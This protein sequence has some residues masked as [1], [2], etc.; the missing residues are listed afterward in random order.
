M[1]GARMRM[2]FSPFFTL[3]PSSFHFQNPAT[4]VASGFTN[5]YRQRN[6]IRWKRTDG[7]IEAVD[8]MDQAGYGDKRIQPG[9]PQ[10][11][12]RHQRMN[13]TLKQYPTNP[14]AKTLNAQQKRFDE[15]PFNLF[16]SGKTV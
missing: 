13:R 15:L 9:K 16:Q 7:A 2:P 6:T 3:R 4:R 10:Q 11:K 5:S 12:G 1:M 8:W 14:A